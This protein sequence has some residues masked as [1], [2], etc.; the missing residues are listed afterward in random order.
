MDA[1]TFRKKLLDGLNR[2]TDE[3]VKKI[4]DELDLKHDYAIDDDGITYIVD[5]KGKRFDLSKEIVKLKDE[6]QLTQKE[7]SEIVDA[8]LDKLKRMENADSSID[9]QE[10]QFAV[11]KLLNVKFDQLCFEDENL[12]ANLKNTSKEN[13]HV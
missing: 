5:K 2:L 6:L 7:T 12:S 13:K 3:D 9:I 11:M 10:Y 8:S 1:L 4:R